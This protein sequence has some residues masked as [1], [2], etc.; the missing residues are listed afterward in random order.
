M[1]ALELTLEKKKKEVKGGRK[2]IER[3]EARKEGWRMK[4]RKRR[5]LQAEKTHR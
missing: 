2:L 5:T 4:A 3:R 1:N